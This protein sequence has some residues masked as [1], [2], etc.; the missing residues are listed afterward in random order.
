MKGWKNSITQEF[1]DFLIENETE[2]ETSKDKEKLRNFQEV[3]VASIDSFFS[4]NDGKNDFLTESCNQ[5][6][7]SEMT[8]IDLKDFK[9]VRSLGQGSF[10]NVSLVYNEKTKEKFAKKTVRLDFN[11]DKL[12]L[13]HVVSELTILFNSN[14]KN[15]LRMKH[16]KI[17]EN[18]LY[19][20]LEYMNGGSLSDVL[21]LSGKIPENI[22]GCLA[23]Q[24]LNGLKYL[25]QERLTVHRDI[26]PSN[27]LINFFSRQEREKMKNEAQ[28]KRAPLGKI[29]L[30]DFGL[31][32]TFGNTEIDTNS[33]GKK[34]ITFNSFVGTNC[35]MDPSRLNAEG[36]SLNSDIWS[37]GL[38]LLELAIGKFP[39]TIKDNTDVFW[40]MMEQLDSLSQRIQEVL[41]SKENNFSEEFIEFITSC[42]NINKKKRLSVEE[43]FNTKFIKKYLK[44]DYERMLFVYLKKKYLPLLKKERE[45]NKKRI[46]KLMSE[47]ARRN[48]INKTKPTI[49]FSAFKG[50]IPSFKITFDG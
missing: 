10:A 19:M 17:E 12:S 35:Y 44:K 38:V 41:H 47:K 2:L 37:F 20:F 39:L 31:S 26:K 16:C 33:I 49:K 27:I 5:E 36:Y 48:S 3:T 1:N 24:I 43:C 42:L 25:H 11:S 50:E 29:T 34:S 21:R 9:N 4:K 45:E 6:L 28:E 30:A 23:I 40:Q 22:V 32:K 14:C 8:N 7:F 18:I 46:I 13:K 15:I